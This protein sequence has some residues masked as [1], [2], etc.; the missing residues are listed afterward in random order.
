MKV[1]KHPLKK[2]IVKRLINRE[3]YIT[4]KKHLEP[5][6]IRRLPQLKDGTEDTITRYAPSMIL[7]LWWKMK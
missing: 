2:Y 7:F 3:K 6:L 4:L 1:L 5:M